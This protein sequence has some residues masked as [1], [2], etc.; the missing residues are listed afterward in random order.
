[1][2]ENDERT[3][4][5]QILGLASKRQFTEALARI[6][7]MGVPGESENLSAC[8]ALLHGLSTI[9]EGHYEMGIQ[10]AL[11][12]LT[13]LE[14]H[15]FRARLDAAYSTI[16][17]AFGVLGSPEIGLE[18][19]NKAIAGAERQADESQLRRSFGDEGQLWAMLDEIEKSMASFE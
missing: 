3:G 12:A 4:V 10:E 17:F 6:N 16:G 18:W 8:R 5:D 2:M 19:V 11:P 15:G 14:S 1:M 9:D 13:Y 7:E